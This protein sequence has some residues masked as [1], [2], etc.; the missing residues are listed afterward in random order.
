MYHINDRGLRNDDYWIESSFTTIC[1][2]RYYE[3]FRN[4][5]D[6]KQLI[7]GLNGNQSI[8]AVNHLVTITNKSYSLVSHFVACELGKIC[9]LEFIIFASN[10]VPRSSNASFNSWVFQMDFLN[11]ITSK[12]PL[13]FANKETWQT[14]LY[15]EFYNEEDLKSKLNSSISNN[16]WLIPIKTNQGCYDALQYL[17][18]TATLR[19]VQ[20]TIAPTHPLKMIFVHKLLKYVFIP[21]NIPVKKLDVVVVIPHSTINFQ[22][23]KVSNSAKDTLVKLGWTSDHIRIVVM[24]RVNE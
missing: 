9:S 22:V 13:T 6:M 14:P 23:G 1:N 12:Q 19:V 18:E 20:V 24:K 7:N 10:M 17:T 5:N 3:I 21:C 4:I 11:R 16:T 15:F 8:L 2:N